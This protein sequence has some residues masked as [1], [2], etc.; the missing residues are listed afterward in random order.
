[1]PRLNG[2]S[3]VRGPPR[4]PSLFSALRLEPKEQAVPPT[5][6][7]LVIGQA[8]PG[9][10]DEPG[11]RM[12]GYRV[13]LSPRDE[14]R[15]GGNV[16]CDITTGASSDVSEDARVVL[17]VEPFED[18]A[19]AAERS[20]QAHVLTRHDTKSPDAAVLLHPVFQREGSG[21]QVLTTVGER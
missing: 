7:S 19:I 4:G 2:V 17:T 12:R 8:V 10:S 9:D 5:R 21:A 13:Q 15:I 14:K 20:A 11:K 1:M 3:R 16:L 6:R 18:V